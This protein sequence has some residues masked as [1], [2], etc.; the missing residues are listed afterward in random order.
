M[1]P[2]WLVVLA[3]WVGVASAGCRQVLG[4]EPAVVVDDAGAADAG[5]CAWQPA[6]FDPCA[7]GAA[8]P[9]LTLAPNTYTYDTTSDG[10][11]LRDLAGQVVVRSS[12]TIAQA[13]QP[14]AVLLVEA[15]HLE[16]GAT[17][18]VIGGKP[19]VIASRST[20]AIDGT[21]D[22]GSH[23]GVIDAN[24]HLADSVQ[25]GAGA[26]QLCTANAGH[27]GGAAPATGGS[28]G[29]GGGGLHGTGG[30]GAPGGNASAA[31]GAGGP[32]VTPTVSVT[33]L[34]GG[35]PGGTS[36]IAGAI[37]T[38]P[39]TP[40]SR[41]L[42][43]AGGGAIRLAAQASITITGAVVASG[44][45][46]AGAPAKSACGGGGG[47][48]GGFIA[49]DAPRVAVSG[50]VI[51]NGG[52]GGGG[53]GRGNATDSGA[54]RDGADG[55]LTSA[56]LGGGAA[57]DG[58]GQPG[59]NGSSLAALDGATATGGDSCGGGGGGGAAGFIVVD[60]ASFSATAEASI[61]PPAQTP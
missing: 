36:G 25:I 44:A 43:G 31:A 39:A 37:A 48:A 58:C 8:Q 46:G 1:R 51:A 21:L 23:L 9:A 10:G 32:A 45:G 28:G 3:A 50:S 18:D 14:V 27:D 59:G 19:L 60:S 5:G 17:L 52:G 33:A 55:A 47:G 2:V 35:C 11:V 34:H 12:L 56:A 24:A 16:A 61:A 20:I 57:S 42:G 41:A 53:G 38:T 54:G 6:G 30:G 29:G 22:A 49:L 15:F 40:A 13:G 7:L 4:F 26:N